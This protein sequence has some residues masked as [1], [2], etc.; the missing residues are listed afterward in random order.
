MITTAVQSIVNPIVDAYLS[1][2]QSDNSKSI[3]CIHT[4][5]VRSTLRDKQT[6]YGYDFVVTVDVIAASLD[7][8]DTLS[9][10]IVSALGDLS[11]TIDG[12]VIEETNFETST[13]AIWN[14]E[15]KTYINT[16]VF[17]FQTKNL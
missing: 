4:E 13:G 1:I 12:T 2:I 17:N 6:I 8:Q 10:A 9:A 14:D 3:A 7:D 5:E 15:A 16:L 11:T